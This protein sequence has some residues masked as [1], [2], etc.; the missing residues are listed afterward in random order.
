MRLRSRHYITASAIPLWMAMVAFNSHRHPTG[1]INYNEPERLPL[2]PSQ[3]LSS[4][5]KIETVKID[6][7]VAF[8]YFQYGN[9]NAIRMQ[10]T[11]A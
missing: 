1:R 3:R 10:V 8:F 9:S 4:C 7:H 11:Y 5:G 6:L 2:F